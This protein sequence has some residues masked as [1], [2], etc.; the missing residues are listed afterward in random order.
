MNKKGVYDQG[1]LEPVWCLGRTYW[2][3]RIG[4]KIRQTSRSQVWNQ[5]AFG[6]WLHATI[7]PQHLDGLH[8]CHL[9]SGRLSLLA[10]EVETFEVKDDVL[11]LYAAILL[12]RSIETWYH[13]GGIVHHRPITNAY[14]LLLR[15][16]GRHS[17]FA[18]VFNARVISTEDNNWILTSRAQRIPQ[19]LISASLPGCLWLTSVLLADTAE[20]VVLLGACELLPKEGISDKAATRGATVNYVVWD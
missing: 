5:N 6:T 2:Q 17:L 18:M 13:P 19:S 1:L 12:L 11:R 3:F 4:V 14:V 20:K 15:L 7:G 8:A 10:Y 16:R 9:L